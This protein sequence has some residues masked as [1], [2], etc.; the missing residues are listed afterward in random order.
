MPV[1]R[2]GSA[3]R[4]PARAARPSPPSCGTTTM[5]RWRS[6]SRACSL[7][8]SSSGVARRRAVG[9]DERDGKGRPSSSMSATTWCDRERR[10]RRSTRSMRSRRSQPERRRREGGDDDLVGRVLGDG[11]HRGR[12]RVG[13][14]DLADDVDALLAHD[15]AREVDAHLR[16]VEHGVVVDDVAVPRPRARHADD[17]ARRRSSAARSLHRLEQRAPAEGLVGDDEDR[18][19]VVVLSSGR[20]GGARGLRHLARRP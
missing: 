9:D 1:E 15:R 12:V 13:V 10:T 8:E 17:E 14:A 5:N 19:H 3:A 4:G 18:P 11:V 6:S 16:G 20:A 7:S 2:A